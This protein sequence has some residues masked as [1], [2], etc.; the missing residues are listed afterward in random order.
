MYWW[1]LW[2]VHLIDDLWDVGG[3]VILLKKIKRI[4]ILEPGMFENLVKVIGLAYSVLPS[5]RQQ[6]LTTTC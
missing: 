2:S 1:L 5:F 6:L 3:D 4:Q